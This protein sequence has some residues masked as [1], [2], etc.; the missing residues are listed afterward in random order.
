MD[1][2]QVGTHAGSSAMGA[3]VAWFTLKSKVDKVAILQRES[4]I[5]NEKFQ[6]SINKSIDE[7]KATINEKVV[8]EATCD[9]CK[10]NTVN[11]F[12]AIDDKLDILI[13]RLSHRREDRKP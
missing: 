5:Q 2:T 10:T 8:H 6:N 3:I 1:I 7:I 9:M 11:Q 4:H 12:K 13:E